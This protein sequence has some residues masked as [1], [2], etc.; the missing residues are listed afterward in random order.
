MG[1]SKIKKDPAVEEVKVRRK[2]VMGLKAK[3][4]ERREGRDAA[5]VC[6]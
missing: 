1:V 6:T 5:S 2:E 4:G 3:F